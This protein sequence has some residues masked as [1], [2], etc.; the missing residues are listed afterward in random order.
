MKIGFL[1][2]GQMG[3]PMVERLKGAGHSVKVYNRTRHSADVL[4]EPEQVLDA[5]V[6]VTMLADDAAVRS[7]WIDS[8]MARKLPAGAIH[9]NMAT[10]SLA[11][12]LE[13]AALQ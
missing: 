1:G 10:V 2:Y 13:R 5:E 11:I 9:L 6:V 12:A 7:V 3:R 8:G 4:S